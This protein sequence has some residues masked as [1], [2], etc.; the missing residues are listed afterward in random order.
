MGR[1]GSRDSH[2]ELPS[3]P[4]PGP[5]SAQLIALVGVGGVL[6]TAA[7]YAVERWLPA[8]TGFPRGTLI[9]NLIGTLV[10]GILLEALAR[11]GPDVGRRRRARL[12]VGTGFCGGLTTYS[13]LAVE[14]DLLIR[15]HRDALA[16]GYAVGSIVA[17]IVVAGVGIAFAARVHRS[18][19]VTAVEE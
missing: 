10:L 11:G 15:A 3:D 8:G 18:V 14:T 7:R 16:A 6:G 17:G 1:S 13:T 2:P 9:V 12:L 19:H 4:D 5:L